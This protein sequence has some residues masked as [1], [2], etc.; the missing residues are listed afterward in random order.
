MGAPGTPVGYRSMRVTLVSAHYPPNFVSGGTL[1]PQRLAHGLLERGH[2]VR[3]FAGCLD[4]RR[5]PLDA[6]TERDERGMPVHWLVTT[7]WIDWADERNH[8]NPAAAEVFRAHLTEHPADVV[9]LHSL[10]G[11]GAGLV[12]E[13]QRAGALTVVTM[14]DF[15]WVCARQFLVDRHQRPCCLV[16]AAGDCACEDGRAH[17][18]RRA[19]RLSVALRAADLV[20]APSRSAAEVLRANGVPDDRLVVDENGM[21][22][23]DVAAAAPRERRRREGTPVVVRYTGGSNPMKGAD[24][25][26]EAAHE[27]GRRPDLRILAH[28]IDDAV[29][30]DGRPLGR[31][32]LE[33]QPPYRPDE[34]DSVLDATDVLVL[35]SV[36]RESHSIVTREAL[37]RGVPAVTT[38]TIGPEEVV[39]DGVNGVV[40]PAADAHLLAAALRDVSEGSRLE[41][42]AR[43][44]AHPPPVR[45][46]E[47]QVSGL[48]SLYARRLEAREARGRVLPTIGRVLFVV[49]I[50]GAPLRYRAHLPAEA[51]ALV[52]VAADVIHYRDARGRALAEAADV[53]VLYRVP[54]TAQ[55]LEMVEE[56]RERG[57]PVVFDVDD[58]IF[59][60]DL[61]EEI[62]A[63]RLLPADEARL[64]LEGVQR[65]RTTMEACDA[66]IGSTPMLVEHARSVVGI[67]AH[68]F[69]NGVGAA[70]GAASDIARRSPRRP[71]PPRVGYL[72]GTTTHD[73]DWRHIEG[74]VVD[75]L[76]EHGEAELW[77]VGHL[78]PTEP[79][80]ARL[81]DRVRR[82]P[83]TE[84]H[85][86]PDTLR[87]LD[88][89]L[90]PLEPGSRFNEAKSAIKWLEAALVGTPTIASP[91][92]P[93]RDAIDPDRT[94]WL[95]ES[96]S[97]WRDA[98]AAVIDDPDRRARV[99]ARA[100][101]AALLRWSPHLQGARYLAILEHVVA[102]TRGERR[103]PS[104]TWD[105]VIADEPVLTHAPLEPYPPDLSGSTRGSRRPR[106]RIPL[107]IVVR[108]KRDR[109]RETLAEEGLGGVARGAGR[110]AARGLRRVVRR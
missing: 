35:P 65:Y 102:S 33:P 67:E 25:L 90:A 99:G 107:R 44:A 86:L 16:V 19:E 92:G 100:Q 3:V 48:E 9:H 106:Q 34:L 40:V 14:H 88:V 15:W 49:G 104:P 75:L 5:T 38:D 103:R 68:L 30:R 70:L 81:G 8:D 79:V 31:T 11:L 74:A 22:A 57:T 20:L 1:Q 56:V 7:P 32:V 60:P 2:D 63:L 51:L 83:F 64:W 101:R 80:L 61:R 59:D 69:E 77:L 72:S 58:L 10:Q 95:A 76:V 29:E 82:V 37:L 91:S 28:D 6:W 36:M 97:D 53:V 13:A 41:E 85:R 108:V 26:I 43:G 55:V 12:E 54:A 87:Q 27:L 46:I 39:V 84:W 78:E 89:N 94:G 23:P 62:P 17:L 105:P 18:D 93:F 73:D 4:S 21:L 98:L 42:L 71:G 96:A 47:E 66:Y 45:S 52:G 50:D 109:F 110:S 24:V